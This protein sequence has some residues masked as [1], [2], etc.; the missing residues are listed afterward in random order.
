MQYQYCYLVRFCWSCNKNYIKFCLFNKIMIIKIVWP[1]I[2][3]W[4]SFLTS[5]GK[6]AVDPI[7]ALTVVAFCVKKT[8]SSKVWSTTL[9]IP[10]VISLLTLPSRLFS[11]IKA[12][13]GD[14]SVVST[15]WR[16]WRW[17]CFRR[18]WWLWYFC[19]S[20]PSE[21]EYEYQWFFLMTF[22]F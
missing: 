7:W 18:W 1:T 20:E 13:L 21:K 16:L 4:L 17:W 14:H 15:P 2:P 8:Q 11:W 12:W 6:I 9:P 5:H 3:N 19:R 10:K 22:W